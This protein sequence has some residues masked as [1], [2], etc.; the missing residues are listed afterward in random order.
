VRRRAPRDAEDAKLLSPRLAY[1]RVAGGYRRWRWY[2][3]WRVHE[4]PIVTEWL[5]LLP[6]GHGLDAGSGTGPY[7][8]A[9]AE[10][11]H[12]CVALDVSL[13]MLR[14]GRRDEETSDPAVPVARVQG[15]IG[16][17]PFSSG[18]FDWLLCTRVLSHV[19]DV[20]SAARELARVL[21]AGG[22]CLIT[23]VHP[24]HPYDHVTIPHN[25]LQV[26][27]DTHKH[28]LDG[29]KAL[30]D[31]SDLLLE[32]LTD[33]RLADLTDRPSRTVFAKLYEHPDRP[34]FYVCRLV[35]V[36]RA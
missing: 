29:L 31:T 17:L 26:A 5:R 18:S 25:G 13:Q 3:F 36:A 10:L 11:G 30:L 21:K 23:D 32:T 19:S 2:R 7:L 28:P 27:I 24:D 20:E 4:T 22:E 33:Y 34:I 16:K 9:I 1:D 12:R 6:R 14:T 15:D 35:K 8:P